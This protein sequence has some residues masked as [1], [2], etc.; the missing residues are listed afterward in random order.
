[1]FSWSQSSSQSGASSVVSNRFWI[2]W[3]VTIPLTVLVI[4]IWRV[5]WLWQERSYQ[6]EVKEAVGNPDFESQTT[7][8]ATANYV[9]RCSKDE[10]RTKS[11]F[12]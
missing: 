6:D 2:Y 10:E 4:I 5:W 3:A 8:S 11:N 9:P 12:A 1:M 7:S